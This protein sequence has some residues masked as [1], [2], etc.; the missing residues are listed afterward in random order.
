L[1]EID[2]V[3]HRQKTLHWMTADYTQQEKK[4]VCHTED[5]WSESNAVEDIHNPSPRALDTITSNVFEECK[6][7]ILYPG[8]ASI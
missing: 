4:N 3:L 5:F 8:S 7:M 2:T 6:K 1:G